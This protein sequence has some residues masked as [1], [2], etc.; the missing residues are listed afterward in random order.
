M[1]EKRFPSVEL[2]LADDEVSEAEQ[3]EIDR[4]VDQGVHT[5]ADARASVLG[6]RSGANAERRYAVGV[7]A[8]PAS[9]SVGGLRRQRKRRQGAEP[10]DSHMVSAAM[11]DAM[12]QRENALGRR[13][14]DREVAETTQSVERALRGLDV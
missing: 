12:Q 11:D 2:F 1:I 13:L 5:P 14:T 7:G 6:Y 4:L 10:V 8:S 9:V 3:Q